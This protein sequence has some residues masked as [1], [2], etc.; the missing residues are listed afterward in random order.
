[1]IDAFLI[2][3]LKSLL[4]KGFTKQD[5]LAEVEMQIGGEYRYEDELPASITDQQYDAW[6]SRSI[7]RDGVRVGPFNPRTN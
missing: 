2:E 3:T 4:D 5:I 7:I 6:Y 1:M